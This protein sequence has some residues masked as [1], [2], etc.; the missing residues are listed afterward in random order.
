MIVNSRQTIGSGTGF[1]TLQNAPDGKIYVNS[2]VSNPD[3]ML[4]VIN[5]PNLPGAA[6]NFSFNSFSLLNRN[7]TAGL[8]ESNESYYDVSSILGCNPTSL[9][10]YNNSKF[11]LL[12]NPARDWI[13]VWGIEIKEIS[14]YDVLGNLCY[15]AAGDFDSPHRININFLHNGIYLVNIKSANQNTTKKIFKN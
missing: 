13:E 4:S 14:I 5:S 6:C 3:T 10:D 7:A 1:R 12:P 2:Y 11:N 8:S 15:K 9:A